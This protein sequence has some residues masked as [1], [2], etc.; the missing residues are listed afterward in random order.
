MFYYGRISH[1]TLF[2]LFIFITKEKH[3]SCPSSSLLPWPT[4]PLWVFFK[5][6]DNVLGSI[7]QIIELD[8]KT[9]ARAL[10]KTTSEGQVILWNAMGCITGASAEEMSIPLPPPCTSKMLSACARVL[11]AP[12]SFVLNIY[13]ARWI[14][15]VMMLFLSLSHP[16]S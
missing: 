3:I 8:P 5:Q 1:S 2:R 9:I 4:T 16:P 15:V 13:C 11:W 12:L 6:F 10:L 7:A 14:I